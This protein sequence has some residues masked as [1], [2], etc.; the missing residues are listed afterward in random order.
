MFGKKL[1]TM[2]LAFGVAA[3]VFAGDFASVDLNYWCRGELKLLTEKLPQGVTVSKRL[4]YSQKKFAHIC[5]YKINVDLT[6]AQE[7]ELQFEVTSVG[8]KAESARLVPSVSPFRTPKDGKKAAIEC[9][10][11]ECCDEVSE[12]VPCKITGWK[13]MIPSGIMMKVG[14]KFTVKGKFKSLND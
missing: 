5:Y 9:L 13:S 7:F 1:M 2:V 14:D 10:E 12:A 4:N 3:G 6:K 11:F 8:D